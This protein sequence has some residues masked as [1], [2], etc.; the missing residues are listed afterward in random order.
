V[1]L[2][3]RYGASPVAG[4]IVLLAPGLLILYDRAYAEPTLLA[5]VLLTL[6]F[7]AAHQ[8]GA[9]VTALAVALLVKEVAILALVPFL[10]RAWR[11][12]D[13]RAAR[14]WLIAVVPYAFWMVWV[15]IRV[16]EFPFL[17]ND[18]SRRG[19]L[20]VPFGGIHD[21]L[22]DHQKGAAFISVMIIATAIAG[23]AAAWWARRV[24]IAGAAAA[25][26][27]FALCTGPTTTA[28]LGETLRLLVIP[29]ALTIFCCAYAISLRLQQSPTARKRKSVQALG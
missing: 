11:D 3:D 19:A 1:L 24:P 15:R 8:R 26:S 17:S 6:L 13:W 28:Y 21:A 29:H 27:L 22:R 20:S 25:F 18:P 4:V 12:R 23:V 9:A 7:E 16:G 5:I 10:W 14:T 2:I